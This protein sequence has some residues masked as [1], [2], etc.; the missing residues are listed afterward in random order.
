MKETMGGN[1][2]IIGKPEINVINPEQEN[3]RK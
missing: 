3:I 2:G 1:L